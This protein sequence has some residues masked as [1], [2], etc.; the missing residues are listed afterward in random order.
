MKLVALASVELAFPDRESGVLPLNDRAKGGMLRGAMR[1]QHRYPPTLLC[2]G[3]DLS[4]RSRDR[5]PPRQLRRGL[6][7]VGGSR[8]SRTLIRSLQGYCLPIGRWTHGLWFS[9]VASRATTASP[10]VTEWV[11]LPSWRGIP[12]SNRS[13]S[14]LT[15]WRGHLAPSCPLKM[16]P[17][18]GFEPP[19]TQV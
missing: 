1:P 7:T 3:S 8:A 2:I 6:T 5:C 9:E 19:H 14:T 16:V 10:S 15:T 17:A 13:I 4:G 12:D 11:P 18:G